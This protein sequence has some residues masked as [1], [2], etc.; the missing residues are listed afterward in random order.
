MPN[1]QFLSGILLMAYGSPD[2]LNDIEP[3]LRNVWG[4]RPV[5]PALVEKAKERYA[6]IGGRSPLL[7]ITRQQA[8]A[9]EAYLNQDNGPR[10]RTYV[11]MRHW[12]P[13]IGEAVRQMANDGIQRAVALVMTP[14]YSRLSSGAYFQQLD[15]AIR[16]LGADIHFTYIESWH[17]HPSLIAALAEKAM[18]A[19]ERFTTEE[20]TP[21]PKVLFTAH[22][23]PARILDQG[24]PYDAQV[25]ETAT[26]L[27]KRMGLPQGRWL[28]CYQSAVHSRETWLGPQIEEVIVELAEA[29][30]RQLLVVPIGFVS[31]HVEVLYDIDITCRELAET[32]GVQL[33][34]SESLNTCPAFIAAL[35]DLVSRNVE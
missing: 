17:K 8:A 1:T 4:G 13:R 22:S 15:K 14:H 19:L 10:F 29:G 12:R 28:L 26:L 18:A 31:D 16:D 30:E 11:G 35:A 21:S 23:L 3:Y 7:D 6:R 5:P 2:S 20:S 27:A 32:H 34:R 24:D 9:L 33:A 25:R